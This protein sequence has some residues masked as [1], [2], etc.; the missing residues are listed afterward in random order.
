MDEVE[1]GKEVREVGELKGPVGVLAVCDNGSA[2]GFV[3]SSAGGFGRDSVA[4]VFRF[5]GAGDAG[6][7]DHGGSGMG[8]GFRLGVGRR[9][10]GFGSV[11]AV[12][13]VVGFFRSAGF[14]TMNLVGQLPDMVL[15]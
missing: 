5:H 9:S 8:D 1:D 6:A 13:V 12:G 11:F 3:E 10:G 15:V 2:G 7:F 14:E 4:E